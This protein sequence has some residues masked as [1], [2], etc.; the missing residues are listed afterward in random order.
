MASLTQQFGGLKCP[1]ISTARLQSKKLKVNPINH[2]NKANKARIVAQAAAVVTNAQTRER[3][4]LKEMFEDAYERCRTAPLE[5]VAFT[6]E[7]FHS[8]LEKYDFDSEVG[9]KVSSQLLHF[10]V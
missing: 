7:D 5:G 9:T 6:V 10:C 2:Q 8:A 4:K 1:P 3:Q